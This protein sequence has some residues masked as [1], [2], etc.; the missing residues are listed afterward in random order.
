MG[1]LGMVV[2]VKTMISFPDFL[3]LSQCGTRSV[4]VSDLRCVTAR[5]APIVDWFICSARSF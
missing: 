4:L 5:R 3:V 2:S 1:F